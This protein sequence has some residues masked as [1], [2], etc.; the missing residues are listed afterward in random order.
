M[1]EKKYKEVD[2]ISKGTYGETFKVEFN[3]T[4]FCKYR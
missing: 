4:Y 2:R 1:D 3:D